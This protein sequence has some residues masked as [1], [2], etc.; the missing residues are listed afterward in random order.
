MFGSL[1]SIPLLFV[2]GIHVIVAA[3]SE[4]FETSCMKQKTTY[5]YE[6]NEL[7]KFSNKSL[8]NGTV[9]LTFRVQATSN[10]HV[11]FSV[12][13]SLDTYGQIYEIVL[14]AG[15]NT[16][17]DIRRYIWKRGAVSRARVSQ[18]DLLSGS[19]LREFT[20][21]ISR[22]GMI[23]I[24]KSSDAIP[25]LYWRD[26]DPI[27]ISYF[28]FSTWTNIYGIWYFDCYGVG[29]SKIDRH[30]TFTES[31]R[32][33][34]IQG[35]DRFAIPFNITE[36]WSPI[37]VSFSPYHVELVRPTVY[38]ISLTIHVNSIFQISISRDGMIEIRKSSDAIPILYWRDP[39]PIP[40]SYFGFSTWTNIYGIWYFDCYG[41][42]TSKIDRHLTF[43]ESL[44]RD[45]I[46]GYDRFA[47]PFNITEDWS[48]INVS[49][50]PYHVE[51]DSKQ[52][53]LILVGKFFL[54][55]KDEK[56][57]WDPAS[58]GN[59]TSLQLIHGEIWKP[60]LIL[61]NAAGHGVNPLGPSGMVVSNRGEVNWNPNSRLQ[62]RCSLEFKYLFNEKHTCEIQLGL[63]ATQDI[64]RL[65]WVE[66][67]LQDNGVAPPKPSSLE[68]LNVTTK[69]IE[70]PWYDNKGNENLD[71]N[72]KSSNSVLALAMTVKSNDDNLYLFV[73]S[74]PVIVF[75]VMFLTCFW[76]PSC[77]DFRG[78]LM[79]SASMLFMA[80][81]KFFSLF[82][83]RNYFVLDITYALFAVW[84]CIAGAA[85]W[86]ASSLRSRPGSTKPNSILLSIVKLGF[87]KS[88][89]CLPGRS[90]EGIDEQ[91][92]NVAEEGEQPGEW[93]A[94][95]W[96]AI[97][98]LVTRITFYVSLVGVI[99][100]WQYQF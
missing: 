24:R 98:V 96:K 43:T 51:L 49:F 3:D 54:A 37:N 17:C 74:L 100:Y 22:D 30:L 70:T 87:I 46:Q 4:A 11:I 95:E 85:S 53:Q 48:P 72:G 61:Y 26:P 21:S 33:D 77:D 66:V 81:Y 42:G 92:N 60:E 94:Q 10:A 16:F 41:V 80:F 89:F 56:L 83:S 38:S 78:C 20:I 90:T 84:L 73:V 79:V 71:I 9:Y 1:S 45:L 6:Y 15:R 18:N 2:I 28:G 97:S 69:W 39:D 58:Y 99:L 13:P 75:T 8:V 55:W 59:I 5:G 52:E 44:R 29:T 63:W 14:G 62:T 76:I 65:V 31:L 19:E 57:K 86:F 93:Y 25:I 32:R 35:Y 23:E 82:R 12:G 40:I 7:F 68:H 47:I 36:D 34:L 67:N 64:F 50:S 27:P 91:H 88:L